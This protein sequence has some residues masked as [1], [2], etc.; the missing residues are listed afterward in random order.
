[1]IKGGGNWTQLAAMDA[2][3]TVLERAVFRPA[4]GPNNVSD[5]R[6]GYHIFFRW[7]PPTAT[8]TTIVDEHSGAVLTVITPQVIESPGQSPPPTEGCNNPNP[9]AYPQGD[10]SVGTYV[11]GTAH[12]LGAYNIAHKAF[13]WCGSG[14]YYEYAV[15][16]Y[17]LQWSFS[18]YGKNALSDDDTT[19]YLVGSAY[20]YGCDDFDYQWT[21]ANYLCT[22]IIDPTL[23]ANEAIGENEYG[24]LTDWEITYFSDSHQQAPSQSSPGQFGAA[25]YA[26]N[27]FL[28]AVP[29]GWIASTYI[30]TA[31]GPTGSPTGA[32]PYYDEGY[33]PERSF[34]RWGQDGTGTVATTMW[35]AFYGPPGTS[36]QYFFGK[37]TGVVT[38]N[39]VFYWSCNDYGPSGACATVTEEHVQD[40]EA[41]YGVTFTWG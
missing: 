9:S 11:S 19:I 3:G 16:D 15:H 4:I 14:G 10:Y 35:A 24:L 20:S 7:M 23:G 17:A 21:F 26:L 38:N 41:E 8:A 40:L 31:A 6:D 2:F 5:G 29:W 28:N 34:V 13:L 18:A 37:A 1:M 25:L 22:L 30:M 33:D 32:S 27:N 39:V 36:T 12:R